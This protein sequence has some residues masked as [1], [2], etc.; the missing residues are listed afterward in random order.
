MSAGATT[1]P[2][3]PPTG[4]YAPDFRVEIEGQPFDQESKGD[5]LTLKVVMELG[6]I[7]SAEIE[8]NNWDDRTFWF[9]YS[10]SVGIYVGNRVQVQF[11]YANR[12]VSM[13]R[14]EIER[15]APRFPE[16]GSPTLSIG[17]LDDMQLL[18]N[19]RPVEGEQRQFRGMTDSG[20]AEAIA[21]R[22]GLAAEVDSGGVTHDEVV[23]GDLDDASFLMQRARRNNYD[24]YIYTDP[25]TGDDTLRFGMPLRETEHNFT[26]GE[27]LKSFTPVLAMSDQVSQVTVRGWNEDRMEEV[28]G[29]ATAADLP[30]GANGSGPG[31]AGNAVGGRQDVI[32]GA[33][34][35][36]QEEA[37]E[38]ARALL[39]ERA[40]EFIT[41]SGEVIGLPDMRPGDTVTLADLGDRFSGS[42]EV[43][44]VEHTIGSSGYSTRFDV[45]KMHEG[46]AP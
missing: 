6:A 31:N 8:L 20:I 40:N 4:Y 2:G 30:G 18:K 24:C 12:L 16:S 44:K 15:L 36:T 43:K 19:R 10:D 26:W 35:E 23:Q 45:R 21:Q 17:V 38:L 25:S 11:G 41:G 27:T 34:V 37:A 22:N 3:L 32:I 9:K 14:G 13:M 7:T 28:I 42:Y 46:S 33:A 39:R 1:V 5:V 29:V